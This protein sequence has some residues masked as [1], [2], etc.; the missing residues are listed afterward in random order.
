A[1]WTSYVLPDALKELTPPPDSHFFASDPGGR[2]AGG[3]FSLDGIH[4]TTVAYGLMAQEFMRVMEEAGVEFMRG[5]GV[6]PRP[7]GVEVDWARLLE[8]D[9]LISHPPA[10]LDADVKLIGWFDERIDVLKRLWGGAA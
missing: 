7:P 5:D 10:S 9:S 8:R 1:W 4:P 2:T 6:T 3:L